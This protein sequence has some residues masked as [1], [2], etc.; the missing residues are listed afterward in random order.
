MQTITVIV[1]NVYIL[2]CVDRLIKKCALY[3]GLRKQI[4][5]ESYAEFLNYGT[6]GYGDVI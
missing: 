4:P 5:I 2:L 3:I 6:E 1:R